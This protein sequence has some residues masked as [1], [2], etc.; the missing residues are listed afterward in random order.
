VRSRELIRYRLSEIEVTGKPARVQATLPM[1]MDVNEAIP[2]APLT[3]SADASLA[4]TSGVSVIIPAHNAA[5]T[6]AATLDSVVRQTHSV[7]EAVIIDDG[8]TD[9]TRAIALHT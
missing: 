2:S 7:W 5:A 3:C 8:S 9:G 6:L 1:G 4:D